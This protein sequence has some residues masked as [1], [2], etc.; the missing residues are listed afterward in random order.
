MKTYLYLP[1][2]RVQSAILNGLFAGFR[3]VVQRSNRV[4]FRDRSIHVERARLQL[5]NTQYKTKVFNLSRDF[6]LIILSLLVY[7]HLYVYTT[8]YLCILHSI[9]VYYILCEYTTF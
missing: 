6:I 1:R 2:Y 8:F 4:A 9:C 3:T 7:N 5:E